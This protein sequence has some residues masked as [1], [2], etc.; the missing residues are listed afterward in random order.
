MLVDAILL[1]FLTFTGGIISLL[2]DYTGLPSFILS[3]FTFIQNNLYMLAVFFHVPMFLIVLA[4]FLTFEGL[5][6]L[7]K[8]LNFII[9]KARGSG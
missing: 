6:Q 4:F 7:F 2:P 3:F 8:G 5:I 1:I 9:K